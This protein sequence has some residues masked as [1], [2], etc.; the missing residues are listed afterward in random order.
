[1]HVQAL[2]FNAIR[3]PFSM[4]DLWGLKPRVFNWE[5]AEVSPQT[6]V[7]S[8]TDPAVPYAASAKASID[9]MRNYA[10]DAHASSTSG[11]RHLL[12]ARCRSRE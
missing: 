6:F 11:Q 7:K 3:M 9:L 10:A 12:C 5:C 2:G 4:K 8:V 1:M